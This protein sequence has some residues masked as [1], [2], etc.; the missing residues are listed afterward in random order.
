MHFQ[1]Q[2]LGRFGVWVQGFFEFGV[3]FRHLKME[4][5]ELA[6]VCIPSSGDCGKHAACID[7]PETCVS[8]SGDGSFSIRT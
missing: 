7:R 4:Q 3:S 5:K 6:H 2:N 1:V 8:R